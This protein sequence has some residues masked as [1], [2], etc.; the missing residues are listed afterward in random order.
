MGSKKNSLECIL[1]LGVS[2]TAM[3]I[4]LID[5]GVKIPMVQE[6]YQRM[7]YVPKKMATSTLVDI[8]VLSA[9][10]F[11]TGKYSFR[12]TKYLK[13]FADRED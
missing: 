8:I 5:A 4:S 1:S 7:G 12:L 11:L 13:L 6:F 2:A 9:S 3:V 10:S